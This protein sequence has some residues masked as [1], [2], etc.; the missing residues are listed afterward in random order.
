MK[1]ENSNKIHFQ[2]KVCFLIWQRPQPGFRDF[3]SKVRYI[4]TVIIDLLENL[5]NAPKPGTGKQAQFLRL[6][7][8]VDMWMCGYVDMCI[9]GYVDMQ[10][11]GYVDVWIRGYESVFRPVQKN[12]IRF[13][14]LIS[15]LAKSAPGRPDCKYPFQT[16]LVF[17]TGPGPGGPFT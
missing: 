11:C 6:E 14:D 10:I 3:G 1:G 7:L 5:C 2:E 16:D 9:C 12:K 13:N 17:Q 8:Y 15:Q 4:N